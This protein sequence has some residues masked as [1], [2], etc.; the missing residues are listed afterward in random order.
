MRR[1]KPICVALA[2]TA[3][4]CAATAA[5]A[6]VIYQENFDSYAN[7]TPVTSVPGWTNWGFPDVPHVIGGKAVIDGR[8][9]MLLNFGNVFA[10]GNQARIEFDSV[11][12]QQEDVIFGPGNAA[13]LNYGE[14]FGFEHGADRLYHFNQ[15]GAD[16]GAQV[17]V[18]DGLAA[19][20]VF[21]L[22]KVGNQVTWSAT[23]GG[24][25]LFPPVQGLTHTF[26]LNDA[27]GVST[28]EWNTLGAT[29]STLDNIVVSSIPEP[30]TMSLL[31]LGG[32]AALRRKR[33]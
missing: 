11:S 28:M 18:A 19:H 26:T 1:F 6:T 16:Y 33:K 3:V 25:S 2:L 13:D 15:N 29:M 5:Q 9:D 32:V 7:G 27:R 4:L 21:D 12:Y 22:T 24:T 23:F 17:S 14:M 30:A 10:L 8:I 20:W 31:A